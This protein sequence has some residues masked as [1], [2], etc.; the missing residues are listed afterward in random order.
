LVVCVCED[1]YVVVA[2]PVEVGVEVVVGID[3]VG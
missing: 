1:E 2:V 3:V